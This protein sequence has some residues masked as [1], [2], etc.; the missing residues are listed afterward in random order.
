VFFG[1]A[2]KTEGSTVNLKSSRMAI[3]FGTT[4]GVMQ[5]AK[6]G[7]TEN[8][9][10]GADCDAEIRDVTAVFECTE[11]ATEAWLKA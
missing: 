5:L 3:K 4:K 7:P 8:S 11:E 9:K 1:F 6:S 10:I 2:D